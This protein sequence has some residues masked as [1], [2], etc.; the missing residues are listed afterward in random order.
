MSNEA[1]ITPFQFSD[2][3]FVSQYAKGPPRFVPGY[4]DLH[5]M[6]TLLLAESVPRDARILVVGA[7]GGLELK[8]FAGSQPEWTYDGVDPA[9]EMLKLAKQTLG[10][11]A[12]RAQL[13]EGYINDAP[14]GPFD[15]ATCL[16]T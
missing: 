5:R 3:E 13:H 12:S 9:A 7:G 1:S 4:S 15:G 6:L 16:L 2:P 8:S 10:P 14:E 11:L